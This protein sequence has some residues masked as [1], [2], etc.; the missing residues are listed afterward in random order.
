M[1]ATLKGGRVYGEWPGLADYQLNE[2][3]DLA[4]TTDSPWCLRNTEQ[5]QWR[6]GFE[7]GFSCFGK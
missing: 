5:A 1:G 7:C 6:F 4:L 2:G 3:R